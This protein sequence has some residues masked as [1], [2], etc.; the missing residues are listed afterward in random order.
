[1]DGGLLDHVYIAKSLSTNKVSATVMIKN[2]YFS[3]Y[4]A[5]QLQIKC[6]M[7]DNM[8]ENIDF[9]IVW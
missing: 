3:D 5:V 2:V 9:T 1:M 6:K 7:L 4:N 8:E